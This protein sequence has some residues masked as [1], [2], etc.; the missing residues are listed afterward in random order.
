[1]AYNKIVASEH[2]IDGKVDPRHRTHWS[3]G[4][5]I[6]ASAMAI[7]A[8]DLSGRVAAFVAPVCFIG[9]VYCFRKD[10]K[11]NPH[12]KGF[13][14]LLVSNWQPTRFPVR[15]N[16][17]TGSGIL[18]IM[19]LAAYSLGV[20]AP[21]MIPRPIALLILLTFPIIAAWYFLKSFLSASKSEQ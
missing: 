10:L 16:L 18:L 4:G 8:L 20:R 7:A 17:L 14:A 19:A 9:C 3:A 2:F 5:A 13:S 6:A 1:V 11:M 21:D 15:V 12:I